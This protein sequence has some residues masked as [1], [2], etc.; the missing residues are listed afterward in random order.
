MSDPDPRYL[1][2]LIAEPGPPLVVKLHVLKVVLG[3][4]CLV[5]TMLVPIAMLIGV[6]ESSWVSLSLLA[7]VWIIAVTVALV[8]NEM[9]QRHFVSEAAKLGIEGAQARRF[10]QT[11]DWE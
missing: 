9:S 7:G 4:G 8:A 2:A 10:F 5:L 11:Y 3:I 6:L 1:E